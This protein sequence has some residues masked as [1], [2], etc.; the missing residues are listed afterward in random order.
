MSI[1]LLRDGQTIAA[2]LPLIRVSDTAAASQINKYFS[3]S[4]NASPGAVAQNLQAYN[5]AYF[6]I[7]NTYPFIETT[8]DEKI[9]STIDSLL[10][11]TAKAKGIIF[12]MRGYPDWGGFVTGNAIFYPGVSKPSVQG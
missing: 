1:G 6:R 4:H 2:E 10:A 12:D 8:A 11:V 7:S 3:V 9:N 5:I